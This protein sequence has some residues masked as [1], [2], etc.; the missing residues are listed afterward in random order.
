MTAPLHDGEV[1][2]DER[3]VRALLQEQAP[4][5]ADLPVRRV[6]GTGTVNHVFRVGDDLAARLPRLPSWEADLTRE[7]D[8]LPVVAAVLP[9]AVPEPV[10]LGVPS[11]AF[12]LRWGLVRWIEGGVPRAGEVDVDGLADAVIALRSLDPA[13]LP[14]AGRPASSDPEQAGA[15]RA[16]VAALDGVDRG[17]V[18]AAWASAR[19]APAWDGVRTAVHADLLPPNLLVRD[20]RLAGV[21]DWG[22]AGAGDP[23]NDLV[24]AWSCFRGPDR[25]RFRDRLAAD[26]GQWARARGI[27]LA[28]AVVAIPYYER[29]MPEFAALNRATLAEVLADPPS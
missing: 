11:S 20:G 13:P 29:S 16:A 23:A 25:A 8:L 7:A 19:S 26:D 27:A 6:R 1:P 5:L 4:H 17:A 24:P 2:A 9:V 3:T 21:L 12:P 28:Q 18:T 10:L 15:V 22:G 14:A